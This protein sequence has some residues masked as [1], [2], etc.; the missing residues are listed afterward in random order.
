MNDQMGPGSLLDTTDSLEAISVFRGWKNFMFLIVFLCLLLVQAAFWLV[1]TGMVKIECGAC[2]KAGAVVDAPGTADANE[3]VVTAAVDANKPVEAAPAETTQSKTSL[4]SLLG[5][6]TFRRLCWTVR[7]VNAILILSACVYVLAILFSLKVSIVGKLGG[8]NHI[9]KAF[10][11]GLF[12]FVLLLP[13]QRIFGGVVM[14]AIYA[15]CELARAYPAERANL[16]A[17]ALYYLRF[18]GYWLLIFFMLMLTQMRTCRW[19]RAVLRR[20]EVV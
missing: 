8:I 14:G 17:N 20:L 7:F 13:W 12:M 10:F 16:F 4:D 3:A 18:S 1:N 2:A 9:G 11:L 15:P 19:T 6:I 5:Q